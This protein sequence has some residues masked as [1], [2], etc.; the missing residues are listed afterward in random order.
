MSAN[1][2]VFRFVSISFSVLVMLVIFIGIFKASTFCYEFGY[3]IFS[4]TPI[5]DVP[6]ED[7]VVYINENA[8][9]TDIAKELEANGLVR[10]DWLF[11]GQYYLSAYVNELLPGKHVLNTSMTAKEMMI[12]MSTPAE[13]LEK[14]E[15]SE[16]EM[17]SELTE[18]EETSQ[19]ENNAEVENE[20]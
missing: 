4:E 6:G 2:V 9:A 1:K 15:N 19:E 3:R 20:A 7:V 11:V 17:E 5:A 18:T 10:D 13:E 16:Q 12:V 14:E 8:S